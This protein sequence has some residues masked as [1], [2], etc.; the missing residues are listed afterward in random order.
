MKKVTL[1]LMTFL[2]LSSNPFIGVQIQAEKVNTNTITGFRSPLI[3]GIIHPQD[4]NK[5]ALGEWE[6]AND[7][8]VMLI[9]PDKG[10]VGIRQFR[11]V[12]GNSLFLGYMLPATIPLNRWKQIIIQLDR[13]NS[14]GMSDGDVQIHYVFPFVDA[15]NPV[16]YS[17][18]LI[19][20]LNASVYYSG[21]WVP[22]TDL[23]SFALP[24]AN[25]W[26]TIEASSSPTDDQFPNQIEIQIDL[27]AIDRDL[28][29]SPSNRP[30]PDAG[31]VG[32]IPLQYGII[33]DT[34]D[35]IFG[36][37]DVPQVNPID[38]E[39]E[40]VV[41]TEVNYE[42]PPINV[43][44]PTDV[45]IAQIE[46]TQST[47][48]ATNG[49]RLVRGKEALARVFISQDQFSPFNVEVVLIV[50]ALVNHHGRIT[51]TNL[52]SQSQVL[53]S[54]KGLTRNSPA[55][56]ANFELNGGV[57]DNPSLIVT[58]R[59]LVMGERWDPVSSNN[60]MQKFFPLETT[61]DFNVYVMPIN[62]GSRLVPSLPSE[63]QINLQ[64][65]YME[66][67]YPI[68][69]INYVRMDW[70]DFG[71]Y[72]RSL[73][74]DIA[75]E[76]DGYL[77][78]LRLSQVIHSMMASSR[79]SGI[80]MAYPHQVHGIGIPD[81]M[82]T[83]GMAN[84][85]WSIGDGLSS[86]SG[87]GAADV[88]TMSHEIN[89]NL[90]SGTWGKHVT[91]LNYGCGAPDGLVA[92]DNDWDALYGDN[93]IH[94]LGWNRVDGFVQPTTPEL[95]TYC[96]S[97]HAPVVW[98]GGYRWER[99]LTKLQNL[100]GGSVSGGSGT[101]RGLQ[102]DKVLEGMYKPS[103]IFNQTVRLISGYVTQDGKGKLLP[104]FEQYG[105]YNGTEDDIPVNQ[106]TVEIK[107]TYVN[108]STLSIPIA[109]SF[110]PMEEGPVNYSPFSR[111]I[112]DNGNVMNIALINS[113]TQA[114]LDI[115]KG[116]PTTPSFSVDFPAG[117]KRGEQLPLD[118]YI[119]DNST[120]MYSE[121]VYSP[122][123]EN[124]IPIS[125]PTTNTSDYFMINRLPGS[126]NAR[127][128]VLMSDGINT[129][130]A[131]SKA[132][133]IDPFTPDIRFIDVNRFVK[134]QDPNPDDPFNLTMTAPFINATEGTN[135]M[136]SVHAN[137]QYG[138]IIPFGNYDWV[139]KDATGVEKASYESFGA[140]FPF[141]FGEAGDYTVTATVT[142][143]NTGFSSSAS[144]KV[145]IIPRV[146]LHLE[147]SY[148]KFISALQFAREKFYS[149]TSN[150]SSGITSTSTGTSSGTSST[151]KSSEIS[152]S[153]T[154]TV[155]VTTPTN[156]LP[157]PIT[158]I[159]GAFLATYMIRKRY[160]RR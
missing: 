110:L 127:L 27:G 53:Y 50:Q 60:R 155:G 92:K 111:M 114:I 137:D 68:P 56:S 138:N 116:S 72:H 77:I 66:I 36:Y 79:E 38:L 4:F 49:Y 140:R 120:T 24:K 83:G 23:D 105:R 55:A 70:R 14:K 76:I 118:W 93:F 112:A 132:Y 156:P 150:P 61:D 20:L 58:A 122:D 52:Y 108:G 135:L 84:P 117:F 109:T 100:P 154:P 25:D 18:V 44:P 87:W 89:H 9:S 146:N 47:Q 88:Y 15:L 103:E 90:G 133:N 160:V 11:K 115:M 101:I 1:L 145:Q 144:L 107:V 129:N 96:R 82:P 64:Q 134:N 136:L 54:F 119:A 57:M 31:Y 12:V 113:T 30:D 73:F 131:I 97:G 128:G 62:N 46:I 99:L 78:N 59:V 149:S 152:S 29:S 17:E 65:T 3:D 71:M 86:W 7:S 5:N 41:A 153:D 124:W 147:T 102:L 125:T 91:G 13:D 67:M 142:D 130:I 42:I 95:M 34:T 121:I 28:P 37:P 80:R 148:Q 8:S 45:G 21:K 157:F 158:V 51:L 35:S 39:P 151:G 143:P 48:T 10:N 74:V 123:G 94:D 75:S 126:P 139:V 26:A 159:F 106:S 19:G 43:L 69:S 22:F 85:R 40:L 2:I 32:M 104:S 63:T 141:K 81:A 16:K 33:I 6:D 98:I